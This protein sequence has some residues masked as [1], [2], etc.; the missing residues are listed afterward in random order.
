MY[1]QR[2]NSYGT[3]S[4]THHGRTLGSFK[5]HYRYLKLREL[6]YTKSPYEKDG[7]GGVQLKSGEDLDKAL[8]D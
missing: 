8:D 3:F 2:R 4:E 5:N 6:T 1:N 7:F